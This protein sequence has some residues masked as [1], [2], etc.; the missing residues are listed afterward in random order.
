MI[1][2]SSY[3]IGGMVFVFDDL[4]LGKE[5]HMDV[6]NSDVETLLKNAGLRAT[7]QRQKVLKV[8]FDNPNNPMTIDELV[9]QLGEGFDRVTAYRIVNCLSE[10]GIAEKVSHLSNTV[11]V[12]L[13]PS[14]QSHHEHLVTCR[15]CGSVS[16]V[17]VCVQ[18]DWQDKLSHLGFKDISHSLSFTGV[19][20]KH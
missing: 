10:N 8:L 13:S 17:Q 2:N 11:K 18:S 16:T 7:R 19:C 4:F 9:D 20:A 14:L 12:T 3:F 1:G 15:L 5:I 6:L